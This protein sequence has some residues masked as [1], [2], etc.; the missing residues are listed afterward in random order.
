MIESEMEIFR[1]DVTLQVQW[2]L[3][4]G[5]CGICGDRWDVTPRP[6]EVG[7]RY[8]NG[9]VT[10]TYEESSV[11]QVVVDLTAAHRG[12]FE[13]RICPTNNRKVEA[14]QACLDR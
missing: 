4:G 14:T 9:I 11:I 3:N 10:R 5:K 7:G 12:Y 1:F 13:F 6:H 2:V 8:A